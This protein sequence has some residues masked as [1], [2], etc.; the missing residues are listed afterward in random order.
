MKLLAMLLMSASA[1]AQ[2]SA[3]DKSASPAVTIEA[4][5][6]TP[7]SLEAKTPVERPAPVV[8]SPQPSVPVI[9]IPP[10]VFQPLVDLRYRHLAVTDGNYPERRQ[11]QLL[12]RFGA[13]VNLQDN[14]AVSIRMMTGTKPN[15]GNQTLGDES[16]PGMPRRDFGLDWAYADYKPASWA[17]LYLGRM[18][19]FF[20]FAGKNQMILDRDIALEGAGTQLRWKAPE[21]LE[22]QVNFGS[23]WI[24]EKYNKTDAVDETDSFLNVAQL[25][26]KFKKGDW[27]LVLGQGVFSYTGIKDGKPP[28][29]FSG[30]GALDSRGNTLDLL[31]NYAWNYE[32]S[33]TSL[34]VKW[35]KDA[36]EASL[37]GEMIRNSSADDFN[38]AQLVGASLGWRQWSLTYLDQ[39]IERDAVFALFTDS[40]FASGEAD[41]QGTITTLAYKLSPQATLGFAVYK[42]KRGMDAAFPTDYDRSQLDLTFT[43]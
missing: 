21:W 14:L 1:F 23:F 30:A 7:A 36:F 6:S 42:Q 15:S 37:F 9:S 41:S 29:F 12:A 34:E 3:T 10:G 43:Y 20:Y 5:E 8:A 17:N 2:T 28:E 19:Q 25:N 39:K 31:N 4:A 33:Q 26:L 22:G 40:D 16:K 35:K 13:K 38:K 24:R 27:S 11:H 18:P 32:M